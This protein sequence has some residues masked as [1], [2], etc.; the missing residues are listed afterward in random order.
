MQ[1]QADNLI[2]VCQLF[3][4]MDIPKVLLK[5]QGT[6][7]NQTGEAMW[8]GMQKNLPRV[9]DISVLKS[10]QLPKRI[11]SQGRENCINMGM[12]MQKLQLYIKK[13]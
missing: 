1:L 4:N 6:I 7:P 11:G 10:Q 13:P 3:T 8:R 12:K 2:P 9:S 5:H